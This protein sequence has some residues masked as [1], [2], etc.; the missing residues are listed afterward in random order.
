M[1]LNLSDG[2]ANS[3]GLAG[4]AGLRYVNGSQ[5]LLNGATMPLET[6]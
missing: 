1:S 3:A 4:L 5:G 2:T 6:S